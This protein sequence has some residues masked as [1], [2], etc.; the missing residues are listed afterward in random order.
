MGTILEALLTIIANLGGYALAVLVVVHSI[1]RSG[2][3][4]GLPDAATALFVL[5]VLTLS[6][7]VATEFYMD[8]RWSNP[9]NVPPWAESTNGIAENIQSEVVQIWIAALVFK[10]LRWPGS[11]ESK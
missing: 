5:W 9:H 3:G 6:F 8:D 4:R 10:Y 7:Y 1:R 11:P 2:S